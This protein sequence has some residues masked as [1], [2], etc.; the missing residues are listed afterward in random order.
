VTVFVLSIHGDCDE[1]RHLPPYFAY[2][3]DSVVRQ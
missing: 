3:A 1:E 2:S